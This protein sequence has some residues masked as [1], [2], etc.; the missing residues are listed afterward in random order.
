MVGL[1][2]VFYFLWLG[3]GGLVTLKN[4][5][6][7]R[8]WFCSNNPTRFTITSTATKSPPLTFQENTP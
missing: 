2:L 3:Q 7:S 4:H 6:Y 1:A 5:G 8:T